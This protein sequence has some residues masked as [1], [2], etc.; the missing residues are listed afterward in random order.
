MSRIPLNPSL[1]RVRVAYTDYRALS[2]VSA[3]ASL[4]PR[5]M[6]TTV[7]AL[8]PLAHRVINGHYSLRARFAR[9]PCSEHYRLAARFARAACQWCGGYTLSIKF[10]LTNESLF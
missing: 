8:A 6:G 9:A 7:L 3:L 1:A 4:V 2:T 5:A 10:T